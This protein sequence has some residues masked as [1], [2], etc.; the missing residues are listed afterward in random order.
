[1]DDASRINGTTMKD[2]ESVTLISKSIV[3]IMSPTYCWR[4]RAP[5]SG[6]PRCEAPWALRPDG[7]LKQ[8][9]TENLL[10][11]VTGGAFG[12]LIAKCKFAREW[13][14]AP[15]YLAPVN[16]FASRV[17]RPHRGSRCARGEANHWSKLAIRGLQAGS[18]ACGN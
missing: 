11:S 10:L 1:I 7:V 5:G 13:R 17:C 9:L 12:L 14:R 18:G 3:D 6:K 2:V 8:I 15:P 16:P 4:D